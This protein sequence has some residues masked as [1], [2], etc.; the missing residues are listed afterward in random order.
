M[1]VLF[2]TDGSESSE[3]AAN[4]LQRIPLAPTIELTLLTVLPQLDR[5]ATKRESLSKSVA[6]HAE[7][8]LAQ[9]SARFDETGWKVS[10][11][12]RQGHIAH[13]IVEAA[14]ALVANLVVVGAKGL[15]GLK[16]FLLGSVSQ[17]VMKYAPCSVLVVRQNSRVARSGDSESPLRVVLAY[18]D[19]KP[20]ERAVEFLASLPRQ[21]PVEVLVVTVQTLITAFRMDLKQKQGPLWREQQAKATSDLERVASELQ[22]LTPHVTSRLLEGSDAAD[23]ILNVAGDFEADLIVL[24]ATGHAGIE[25]FLLG[26]V[27]NR[28]LHHANCSVLVVRG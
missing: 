8:L 5:A 17:K 1:H 28:V 23:E 21:D 3:A 10:T 15:S 22:S 12:T 11:V 24:G 16:R 18:D 2:A 26:S 4:L 13:E 7:E 19:S 14:G 9:E 27:A 6:A 25:R 20:A